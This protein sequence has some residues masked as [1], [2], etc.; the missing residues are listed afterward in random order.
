VPR[1]AAFGS[2]AV[3]WLDA[4]PSQ[5][6]ILAVEAEGAIDAYQ[7]AVL[8]RAEGEAFD[9]ALLWPDRR[10]HVAIAVAAQSLVE[11]PDYD[12][13][14]YA[15]EAIARNEGSVKGQPIESLLAVD[16]GTMTAMRDLI[17]LSNRLLVRS[18][19]EW[20]RISF[21]MGLAIPSVEVVEL[22]DASVPAVERK[23]PD[24]SVL[25]WAPF[26]PLPKLSIVVMALLEL[27]RP[28]AYVCGEGSIPGV[29]VKRIALPD[30]KQAL[31]AASA[32]VVADNDDPAP[33]R[34]LARY[35]IPVC[36]STTSGAREFL[37]GAHAFRPWHRKSILSA[38]LEALGSAAPEERK[39][40][41]VRDAGSARRPA[42]IVKTPPLVSVVVRTYDRPHF[43]ERALGSIERQ[44]YPHVET[45]VVNDAGP[46]VSA[47]VARFG[48]ARLITQSRNDYRVVT[49][50]GM[51]DAQGVYV[52]RLDDDDM[53][54]PEH[55]A[56]LVE[57]L[58]RTRESVALSDAVVTYVAGTPPAAT[59]YLV[60]E[61]EPVELS[62]ML[63]Q[64]RIVAPLL[65]IL[66]RKEMLERVGW[67]S[68]RMLAADDYDLSLRLLRECDF[69]RV[70][71]VTTMYTR[72]EDGTNLST[73]KDHRRVEAHRLIQALHPVGERPHLIER[74]RRVMEQ[75]EREGT[76]GIRKAPWRFPTPVPLPGFGAEEHSRPAT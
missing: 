44:T 5:R 35:G 64:N 45:I 51:R 28:V 38:V 24:G 17:M 43:L 41:A 13:R 20:R 68:E 30:A 2:N 47:I 34:A 60:V 39:R 59:C 4:F 7:T 50:V 33:A 71:R 69:L 63:A 36:A 22:R 67:F 15:L 61:K 29:D 12:K 58:E 66:I 26:T 8:L 6:T 48:R 56:L 16:V 27:H 54:F 21:E 40:I 62:R 70:D 9:L 55:L 49:N 18:W 76:L 1:S 14:R 52:A 10:A 23:E 19:S 72:F 37:A 25:I 46:D 31:A 65:R 57:A 75:L 32:V 3:R 73:M 53:Y 42:A 74:R 11:F